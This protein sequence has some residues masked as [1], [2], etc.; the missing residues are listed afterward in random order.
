[1]K[2]PPRRTY[3]VSCQEVSTVRDLADHGNAGETQR[4]NMRAK[5]PFNS[6]SLVASTTIVLIWSIG[7]LEF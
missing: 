5:L 3:E 6:G 7:V 2:S 4:A 1:M